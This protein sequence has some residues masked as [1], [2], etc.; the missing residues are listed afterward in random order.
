MEMDNESRDLDGSHLL[1]ATGR[2][3]N[4]DTLNRQTALQRFA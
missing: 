4:T 1:V 3:P 2:V